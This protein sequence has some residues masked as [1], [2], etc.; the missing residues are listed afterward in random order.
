MSSLVK[1]FRLWWAG[2][3]LTPEDHAVLAWDGQG[4]DGSLGRQYKY[5]FQKPVATTRALALTGFALAVRARN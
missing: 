3:S 2:Q 1:R 5:L 4:L